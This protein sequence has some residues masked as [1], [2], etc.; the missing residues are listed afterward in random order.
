MGLVTSA[1]EVPTLNERKEVNTMTYS[2]PEVAVLGEA[3]QVILG[4]KQTP[5]E[6]SQGDHSRALTFE[7]ED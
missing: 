5:P 2:K 6:D 1:S 3:N 4:S 7:L